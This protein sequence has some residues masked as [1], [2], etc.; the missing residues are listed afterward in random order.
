V[1]TSST[2]PCIAGVGSWWLYPGAQN[3]PEPDRREGGST[4]RGDI[5]EGLETQQNEALA[6]LMRGDIRAIGLVDDNL[7]RIDKARQAFPDDVKL[8]VLAGY[9]A[10]NAY[11]SA[12]GFVSPAKRKGYLLRARTAFEG[13]LKI[14]PKDAGAVNGM[15]TVLFYE[16]RFDEAIR[17]HEQAISLQRGDYPAAVHDLNLVRQVKSGK[18][19]FDP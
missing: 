2:R 18:V 9:A 7:A 19:P 16:Q 4:L 13:A 10:K 6:S 11:V 14:D 5:R 17:Y 15:G 3:R 12:K 8:L 1:S